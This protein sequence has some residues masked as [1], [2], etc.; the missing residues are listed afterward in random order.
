MDRLMAEELS[1]IDIATAKKVG[2]SAT[3]PLMKKYT[4]I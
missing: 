3:S 2:I 1:Q 4:A